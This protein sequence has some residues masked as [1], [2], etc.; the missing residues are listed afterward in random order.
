MP[1]VDQKDDPAGQ[2]N[3]CF[4]PSG[5]TYLGAS[6]PSGPFVAPSGA[7]CQ[8]VDLANQAMALAFSGTEITNTGLS[9]NYPDC[10]LTVNGKTIRWPK[11][12]HQQPAMKY[13]GS[14][15]NLR[16]KVDFN[17]AS[18]TPTVGKYPTATLDA[19]IQPSVVNTA[20]SVKANAPPAVPGAPDLAAAQK[21]TNTFN[22]Q[23]PKCIQ[24]W[25]DGNAYLLKAFY[26]ANDNNKAYC[27]YEL[28]SWAVPSGKPSDV[29]ISGSGAKDA[30]AGLT[31]IK[32]SNGNIGPAMDYTGATEKDSKGADVYAANLKDASNKLSCSN[33]SGPPCNTP[34]GPTPASVTATCTQCPGGFP[35]KQD[36]G[37]Q[38]ITFGLTTPFPS[39][40]VSYGGVGSLCIKACGASQCSYS[41]ISTDNMP[42]RVYFS[43]ADTNCGSCSSVFSSTIKC[44]EC[45]QVTIGSGFYVPLDDAGAS[46]VMN[47]PCK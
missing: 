36:A 26:D 1:A 43:A 37:G 32:N 29:V 41:F 27:V 8:Y 35:K 31:F 42:D 5:T 23:I 24:K 15:A 21:C 19:S 18:T 12:G 9:P 7:Q 2:N 28:M 17:V 47:T 11:C 20:W 14:F 6:C 30:C 22:S 10:A 3:A 25:V 38:P 16:V 13:S 39:H 4:N 44:G 33:S 45:R 34:L 40:G 46:I